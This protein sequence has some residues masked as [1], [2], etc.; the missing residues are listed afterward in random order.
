MAA[1][2]EKARIMSAGRYADS[3]DPYPADEIYDAEFEALIRQML[4]RLGD[5]PDREGLRRTPLRVAKA[6][7]F[8][9]S[10][11]QTDLNEVVRDAIFEEKCKEMVLVRDIE[12]YS[13]C[14]HHMLPFFGNAHV[15]YLPKGKVIGLSKIAR[16]VDVYARRL[17]V[18]ER[19]T[20]Q[21]AD[22]LMKVLVPHGVAVVMEAGHTCMMMRGVQKQK[23]TTVT[24][25]MRGTFQ[26]DARTRMEFMGLLKT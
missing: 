14:E 13:L 18:Q 26:E 15:A 16:V 4:V 24:S 10:G 23:S 22:A 21:V 2:R 5:D 25:A 3:L 12:F 11:Y 17:Q 7:D 8:L 9:T 6:M 1:D 20:N 19:L